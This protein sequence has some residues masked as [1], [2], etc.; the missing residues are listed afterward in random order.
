[1]AKMTDTIEERAITFT[2]DKYQVS[3][4]GAFAMDRIETQEE[5]RVEFQGLLR[6]LSTQI[7]ERKIAE[8]SYSV[9]FSYKIPSTWWQQLKEEKAPKWFTSKYPVI[10]TDKK[11]KRTVN[12][13]RK[14]TYPM[15]DI[16]VPKNMGQV[17]IRDVVSPLYFDDDFPPT[18]N[19]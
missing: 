1:M 3:K 7:L 4:L 11:V 14:A 13:T 6:T 17:V 8:D 19:Y 12:I 18:T 5:R 2:T 9:T 15:A 16:V 10:Y